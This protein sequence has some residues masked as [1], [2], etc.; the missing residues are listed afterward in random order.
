[1]VVHISIIIK[2]NGILEN[3]LCSLS[4]MADFNDLCILQNN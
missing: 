1:M 3:K 4:S 2:Q